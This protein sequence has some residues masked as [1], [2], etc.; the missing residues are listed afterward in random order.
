MLSIGKQ[1][2]KMLAPL[3]F[4]CLIACSLGGC[5]SRK[6]NSIKE[7]PYVIAQPSNWQNIKLYGTEQNITGFT[8][9][10]L[11]EI[12]QAGG[13][14]VRIVKADPDLFKELLDNDGVDGILTAIPVDTRS[15]QFFEFSDPYFVTGTVVVVSSRSPYQKVDDL[16]NV[17]IG[18]D[19]NEG[20]DLVLKAKPSWLLRP[21]NNPSMMMEDLVVER[22]DGVVMRLINALRMN[23]S[24]FKSKI[25]I[26]QPPLETQTVR[27]A[28]RKGRN[29]ELV[30][31][32]NNGVKEYIK[33]GEY[34][35]LLDYWG[36]ESYTPATS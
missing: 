36:I 12:A 32:F 17:Q 11:F 9:D 33:S 30:T 8:A 1:M 24:F 35:T 5:F 3:F 16:K 26:L 28:V 13:F 4:A 25:R 15:Q 22:L 29:H 7:T 10:L 21:Y 20:V 19:E 14:Q 18:Y 34:K 2:Y 6:Q 23:K 31:L 27:L